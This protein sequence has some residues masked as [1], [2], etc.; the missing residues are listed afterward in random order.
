[1]KTTLKNISEC[2]VEIICEIP[3]EDFEKEREQALKKISENVSLP[4]FRKG[5]APESLVV[6]N[7]GEALILE[8]M[9]NL[10]IDHAYPKILLEHKMMS[11]GMPSVQIKKLAKGNPFEFSLTFPV[12]PDI[13]LSDYKKIAKEIMKGKEE[14]AVSDEENEKAIA[15]LLKQYATKNDKEE[16]VLPELTDDLVKKFGPF[17]DVKEF[18]AKVTES[19][20]HEKTIRAKEKKRMQIMEKIIESIT[21]K[22]PKILIEGELDHMLFR[23][24]QDIEQMGMKSD[25]YLTAIKKTEEDFRKE[26]AVDAEKRVKVQIALGKIAS[27]EKIEVPKDELDAEVKFL[28]DKHKDVDP[29]RAYEHLQMMM[30]NEKT[31]QFLEDQK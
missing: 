21:A 8:E 15:Q 11:I 25:D 26:W 17:A 20:V 3:V 9:A 19:I 22:L 12:L 14:V 2:E 31:F 10:A 30:L 6:K 23:F 4:G 29:A 27:A 16:E 28:T 18:K 13:T 5:H 7:F 1:M 24:R